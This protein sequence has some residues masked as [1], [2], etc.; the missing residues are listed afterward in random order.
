MK[1]LPV[2]SSDELKI[3][4]GTEADFDVEEILMKRLGTYFG[5]LAK[6]FPGQIER[7]KVFDRTWLTFYTKYKRAKSLWNK[8]SRRKAAY[9]SFAKLVLFSLCI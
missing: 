6:L 7:R 3:L 4:N 2:F 9:V 5:V 1:R 8:A